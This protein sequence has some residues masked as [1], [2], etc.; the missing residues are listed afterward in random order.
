M[1]EVCAAP[2][3]LDVHGQAFAAKATM[4]APG[5]V[6]DERYSWDAMSQ[7]P[8]SQPPSTGPATDPLTMLDGVRLFLLRTSGGNLSQSSFASGTTRT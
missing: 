1:L 2:T 7:H 6:F 5:G 3:D 4:I 8:L